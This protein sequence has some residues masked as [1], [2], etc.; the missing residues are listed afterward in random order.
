MNKQIKPNLVDPILQKKIFKTLNP[1]VEDYWAPT[2]NSFQNF[3]KN[4]IRPNIFLIIFIIIL[5]LL[6][7][8]RYRVVKTERE[9]RELEKIY[10]G[11]N[12]NNNN[13]NKN[14]DV[15]DL[16]E[17]YQDVLLYLYNQQKE[18]MREPKIKKQNSPEN[19]AYPVYPYKG[20]LS[21]SNSR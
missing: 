1:P 5:A 17:K 7:Y 18:N 14:I 9:Q 12:N 20:S 13:N 21:P 2:K 11:N 10:N 4:F 19:F 3:Y 15:D 8:Y 6:L 16:I